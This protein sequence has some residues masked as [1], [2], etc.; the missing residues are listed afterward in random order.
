MKQ[1]NCPQCGEIL[2]SG[3]NLKARCV[4][5]GWGGS[6]GID[7]NGHHSPPVRIF[8]SKSLKWRIASVS[9]V[10]AFG[11]ILSTGIMY[12]VN[13]YRVNRSLAK[14]RQQ[15]DARLYASAARTLHGAP[16]SLV[17]K[18]H[19]FE[20]RKLLVDNVRWARDISA[21]KTAKAS[22]T[23]DK[24]DAALDDLLDIE[25]DFPHGE[26]VVELIDL[27]QEQMLDP[28]LDV[29]LEEVDEI[30]FSPD[31][32]GLEVLDEIE[33]SEEIEQQLESIEVD[34]QQPA[35]SPPPQ[36]TPQPSSES[37]PQPNPQVN[38]IEELEDEILLEDEL[39]PDDELALDEDVNEESEEETPPGDLPE[40]A[41]VPSG[42]TPSPPPPTKTKLK[43]FFHL[44]APAIDDH[45]H[46]IDIDNEVN[47]G[48][49]KK[50]GNT[51]YANYGS[52]GKIYNK[53]VT[54]YKKRIVPLYRYWSASRADHVYTT[55]RN[56]A[57]GSSSANY[58]KQLVAGY[59]GKWSESRGKCLAGKVPLYSL[60]NKQKKKN[61]ITTNAQE[62]DGL[63]AHGGYNFKGSGII[64]CVW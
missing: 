47:P 35:N 59:I 46:T 50:S 56:F 9:A 39:L 49:D 13:Q 12:P 24:P 64:G 6:N 45:L 31:D 20:V 28:D 33:A 2:S 11:L 61:Y 29:G 14:A 44:Y 18:G 32:P 38:P 54:K 40:S 30:A 63:K 41:P 53:R 36:S 23:D 22:M 16:S 27:A 17:T 60:Y 21:V 57:S 10:I 26:E 52:I 58:Q 62:R 55:K 4:I 37:S 8:L 43:E 3:V 5:C 19:D 25:E 34:D 42:V 51:G 48:R 15:M 1:I 7:L